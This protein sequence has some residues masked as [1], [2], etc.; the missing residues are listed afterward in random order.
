MQR[1]IRVEIVGRNEFWRNAVFVEWDYQF[2]ERKLI[3]EENGFH[4]IEE[5]WLDDLQ[6]V[7]GQCFSKALLAPSDPGRRN[8]FRK[9]FPG[10][11]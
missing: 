5:D 10:R 7:A 9:I 4:L 11:N 6:R 8:L 1:L 2:P 3:E